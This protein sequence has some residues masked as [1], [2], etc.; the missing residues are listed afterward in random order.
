MANKQQSQAPTAPSVQFLEI[1]ETDAGQRLDNFLLR[2]LKGV[3]KSRIYR[4]VRHGEVRINKG[5]VKPDYRLKDGDIVR[6]PPIR[7]ASRQA[8]TIAKNLDWLEDRVLFEDD[9]IL[10]IDKP[11]GMAVHGGS[12]INLGLIEALRQLRPDH[13]FLELVHRLDRDTSGVL[14][15]A[16]KRSALKDLHAQLRE[17]QTKKI[18]TA[19]LAGTWEGKARRIEASLEKNQLRSGERM[20]RVSEEGKVAASRFIPSRNYQHIE[21]YPDGASLVEINLLT[22]R[23]HQARVHAAHIGQPIAG[24]TKYGSAEFNEAMKA[25]G[26]KRLFL[27]ASSITFT[28]PVQ[29][30]KMSVESPLAEDL[31]QVLEK[32]DR[33]A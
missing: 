25:Y 17:G 1:D 18:Y 30:C 29:S 10:A 7:T 23:T 12:G 4:I 26:L 22:G 32:L 14:L 27:H 2:K 8:P 16:K 6:I 11:S 31:Q 9:V 19:L 5:R 15:I 33:G 24:D 28:H 3:P 13:R 20:V 21:T